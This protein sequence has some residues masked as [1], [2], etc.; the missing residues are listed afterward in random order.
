MPLVTWKCQGQEGPWDPKA[1]LIGSLLPSPSG[2]AQRSHLTSG[3][4][5]TFTSAFAQL[6]PLFFR[7]EMK[8]AIFKGLFAFSNKIAHEQEG[9]KGRKPGGAGGGAE[10]EG[11]FSEM[12]NEHV[13]TDPTQDPQQE[14][15]DAAA[16]AFRRP[17]PGPQKGCSR[18]PSGQFSR[19]CEEVS[20]AL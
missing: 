19:P 10:E 18:K 12:R 1:S 11:R 16:L 3:F 2:E 8:N 14:Q 6:C 13:T 9:S 5:A 17:S 20:C 4:F 7:K 15:P